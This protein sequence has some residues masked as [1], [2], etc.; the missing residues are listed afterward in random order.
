MFYDWAFLPMVASNDLLGDPVALRE[1]MESDS[2]LY[3][4]GILDVRKI[5]RLRRDI[6]TTLRSV[7]WV[8][9]DAVLTRGRCA[10]LPVREGSPEFLVAYDEVQKLESF[11]TLAHDDV[12]LGLMRDVLGESAFPHPLKIAR[13]IFPGHY[14]ISTPPH[15]DYPN[16]QGTER[17]TASW[18]PVGDLPPEMGGIAI[19]RGS[20]R[21][22]VLPL[23]THLGAGNRCAVLPADML[24]ECR[25]VTTEFR[26]G[27][28]LL[29]PSLTVHAALHNAS[30]FYFRISVDFRYQLE[31]EALTPGCLE[32][33]FGRLSW[34]DIYSGWGSSQYQYYW[35]DRDY[36]VVPFRDL[37]LV[38]TMNEV[39]ETARL[40]AYERR[41]DAR[42]ARQRGARPRPSS[43]PG[44]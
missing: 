25:W 34:D 11:H 12:L 5:A 30:E 17:L 13:I 32:P 21:W 27:D 42:H 36:E 19:L 33:H 41:R 23:T 29:F 24:E 44:S 40:L 14:E 43:A 20:H 10:A 35:R 18:I 37:E 15:Q 6:L 22:G 26:A 2:Y 3:F 4:S 8:D 28:V 9:P 31:G 39:E 7:G 16:N 1:R 38:H